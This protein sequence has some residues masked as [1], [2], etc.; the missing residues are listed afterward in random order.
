MEDI[1]NCTIIPIYYKSNGMNFI[2]LRIPV[3]F[4]SNLIYL[5]KQI[6]NLGNYLPNFYYLL[7]NS[8]KSQIDFFAIIH[9]SFY[10]C[11]TQSS[12]RETARF[13]CA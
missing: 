9:Y 8:L 10:S 3:I 12:A 5:E 13:H 2:A 11:S 7:I 4:L 1:F 6:I